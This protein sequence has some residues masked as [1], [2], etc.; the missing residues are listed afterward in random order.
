MIRNITSTEKIKQNNNNNIR[1]LMWTF[2][3]FVSQAVKHPGIVSKKDNDKM[4]TI[5]CLS[6]FQ[7]LQASLSSVV[8]SQSSRK[9]KKRI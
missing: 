3:F 7:I 9:R 2:I 4:K 6:S 8:K 1:D 5:P